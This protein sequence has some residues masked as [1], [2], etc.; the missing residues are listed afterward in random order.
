MA[1]SKHRSVSRRSA[2]G[3]SLR[4]G[5]VAKAYPGDG[6]VLL[7]FDLDKT[8]TTNL[9]GFAI[10]RTSPDGA[11]SYLLNRLNFAS[12]VTSTTSPDARVWTPSNEAPFQKFRWVDF[13]DAIAPGSYVYEVDAMYFDSKGGLTPGHRKSLEVSF[14]GTRGDPM[15]VNFTRGYLSSQAYAAKFQNAPI[16]PSN[17]TIDFPTAQFENQYAWLG[18][19]AR[20]AIF[21]FLTEC[22]TDSSCSVDVFAYD[23]DEPDVVRMLVKLGGRLRA[24]LDDAPLHTK[25]SALEP[26]AWNLLR[27]SAGASN[28]KTGHFHRFA[29]SKV[30]IKKDSNGTPVNVLTGSA[31]FS[32]RGLYVQ[33]NN[34]LVIEDGA[35]AQLYEEAFEQAFQDEAKFSTSEIADGWHELQEPGLPQ[36]DVAFSPHTSSTVSL[37]RVAQAIS[38]AKKSVLFAV[39]ELGGGGP[40]LR[41]LQSLPARNIFSYGM[42]QTLS[43]LKLYKPG[44]TNGLIVPFAFLKANVPA[45]FQSEYGGGVGEVIHH[46]FVVVDFNGD[47]PAVFCGSSNLSSGG[48]EANGDNLLAIY[49]AGMASAYAVE[50]VR[51]VDHYHFRAAMQG[52]TE[53]QPL[54]LQG[55]GAT[56]PWWKPY[57]DAR[58]IKSKER[59]TFAH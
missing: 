58:N 51:L 41:E 9:A 40:V 20:S 19:H 15:R 57:Y 17:K 31:N 53:S 10:K 45:P 35:T 24:F 3:A 13:P 54:V 2:R 33:A 12:K 7:A 26:K 4:G 37:D 36:F 23:L 27:T 39:M 18:F 25:P 11:S 47:H 22:L 32:V 42:T 44:S 52:A 14:P 30:L 1:K 5:L 6:S 29:H 8:L 59:T 49:D 48:E 21:S 43:G 50:A 16:R 34:V 55:A 28:I 56:T 46:K 38:G